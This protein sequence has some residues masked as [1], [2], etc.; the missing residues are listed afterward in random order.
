MSAHLSLAPLLESF[1]RRR[2]RAQAKKRKSFNRRQLPRRPAYV[3]PFRR[4]KNR[5]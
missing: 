2:L 4:R 3:G 1:F 5:A